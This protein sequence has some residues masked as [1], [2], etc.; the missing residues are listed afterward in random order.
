MKT[1]TSRKVSCNLAGCFLCC[2]SVLQPKLPDQG[3]QG[4]KSS[5]RQQNAEEVPF[6]KETFRPDAHDQKMRSCIGSRR[7]EELPGN[8]AVMLSAQEKPDDP[9]NQS[10]SGRNDDVESKREPGQDLHTTVHRL[11]PQKHLLAAG[12]VDQPVRHWA[13][14]HLVRIHGKGTDIVI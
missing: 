14:D 12:G 3:N 4:I 10:G 7:K 5:G 8:P 9:E 13:K 11:P 6:H 2:F 1:P